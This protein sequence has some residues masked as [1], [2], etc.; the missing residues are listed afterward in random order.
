MFRIESRG[1]QQQLSRQGY[2][3]VQ[4]CFKRLLPTGNRAC[5]GIGGEWTADRNA[6]ATMRRVV[7]EIDRSSGTAARIYRYR[8]FTRLTDQP[9]ATDAPRAQ[10]GEERPVDLT[11]Q[12][13]RLWGIYLRARSESQEGP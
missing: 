13:Q 2:L 8:S 12:V 1:L 3:P 9:M 11:E 5:D 6:I 4:G 7:R 10:T